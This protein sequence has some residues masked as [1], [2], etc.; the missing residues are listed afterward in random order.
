MPSRLRLGK[1]R[2]AGGVEGD[3]AF[4][5][6]HDLMDVAVEHGNGTE[7]LEIAERLGAVVSAP[8]PFGVNGPQGDVGED[9]DGGA[10]LQSLDVLL[11]PF[12]LLRA[13]GAESAGLE[14]QDVDQADKMDGVLVEAVPTVA[15][16]PFAVAL[17]VLLAVVVEHVVLAGDEED[18]VGLH[19]LEHL[20]EGI[21]LFGLREMAQIAGVNDEFRR[22]R[23]GVDFVDGRGEGGANV[24]IGGLVEAH[25]AVADLHKGKLAFRCLLGEA[26]LAQG[27]GLQ[28]SALNDAEGTGACPGHA[29]E[30]TAAVHSIFVQVFGDVVQHFDPPSCECA[31]VP[32]C[33][34]DRSLIRTGG[35]GKYS[36]CIPENGL[37]VRWQAPLDSGR[38][39]NKR[40]VGRFILRS[41]AG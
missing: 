27:K 40:G 24:G 4:H 1:C 5:L 6:L 35:C 9:H 13:E 19:A 32:W 22:F 29:L 37:G 11:E 25:V 33:D 31:G 26:F 23:E 2:G 39:G 17:E 38:K 28:H 34:P 21:E 7:A 12:Q 30:K 3:V 36:R 10:G 16:R 41:S 20:V 15:C 18:S 8:T 14:I